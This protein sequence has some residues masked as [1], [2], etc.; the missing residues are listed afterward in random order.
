MPLARDLARDLA[1]TTGACLIATGFTHPLEMLK[2]RLMLSGAS[3]GGMIAVGRTVVRTEGWGALYKG[4]APALVRSTIAGVRH[5]PAQF[6][7]F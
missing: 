2:T 7:P 3:S 5:F 1:A 6:P 4:L